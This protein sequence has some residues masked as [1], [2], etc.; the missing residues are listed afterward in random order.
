MVKLAQMY[1]LAVD[2]GGTKI[3]LG[4]L[5]LKGKIIQSR[6]VATPVKS[7]PSKV[8]SLVIYEIKKLINESGIPFSKIKGLGIG[9]PGQILPEEGLVVSS[10]NLPLWKNVQLKKP[11]ETALKI[12]VHLD[13]DAKA[14]ALGE[15][16]FG[17]GRGQK[18]LLFVTVSTGIGCGIIIN[19]KI[20]RG[21]RNIAGEAGHMIIKP[22]GP[23]CGCGNYGCWEALAAGPAFARIAREKL[24]NHSGKT[25]LLQLTGGKPEKID[26]SIL[27]QA[28]R[29]GDPLAKKVW[30][31]GTYYLGLG[32]VNLINIFNPSLIVVGG[33]L[34]N[35]GEMLLQPVRQLIK[36]M[37]F[38]VA[39][40]EVRIVPA[41]LKSNAGLLGAGA[42]VL[43]GEK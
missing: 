27:A 24:K 3:A 16:H 29:A 30:A 11:L 10:P 42:L 8:I 34:A 20:Y 41:K 38:S 33:G 14:A 25:K 18:N 15:L 28:V 21:A 2:L 1:I 36:K 4:L 39:A 5:D 22:D 17:A 19:G 12:P 37:G 6:T 26:G 7:S 40:R 9:A 13:N 23:K 35:A 43:A 32:F 31:E